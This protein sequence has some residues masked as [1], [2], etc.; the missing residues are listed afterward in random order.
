MEVYGDK[1]SCEHVN[2]HTHAR[3]MCFDFNLHDWMSLSFISSYSSFSSV[4]QQIILQCISLNDELMYGNS[5]AMMTVCVCRRECEELSDALSC[6]PYLCDSDILVQRL[7]YT[8]ST[9]A[10]GEC[11]RESGTGEIEKSVSAV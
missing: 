3:T 1:F 10:A 9:A 11:E 8:A 2:I 6:E 7:N 4:C 5:L